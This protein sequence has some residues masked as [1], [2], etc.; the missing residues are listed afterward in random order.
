[1]QY[2][3]QI[4]TLRNTQA[5]HIP[6]FTLHSC[7]GIGIISLF[8]FNYVFGILIFLGRWILV[9]LRKGFLNMHIPLRILQEILTYFAADVG[10]VELAGE[11]TG[12]GAC[13]IFRPDNDLSANYPEV[14]HDDF[15]A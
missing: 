13:S 6:H 2:S 14:C 7:V 9:E 11:V 1:M 4:L 3:L 8:L 12:C 5:V 15:L 10:I